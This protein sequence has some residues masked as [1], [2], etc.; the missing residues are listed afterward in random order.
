MGSDR[1]CRCP[2]E[3]GEGVLCTCGNNAP[4][5]WYL[6]LGFPNFENSIVCSWP[7]AG[8][9]MMCGCEYVGGEYALPLVG[10]NEKT[11]CGGVPLFRS[12]LWRYMDCSGDVCFII[13]G[14]PVWPG[15][16]I[17]LYTCPNHYKLII[18]FMLVYDDGCGVACASWRQAVYHSDLY[19]GN[20]CFELMD[21]DG[22]VPLSLIG[23]TSGGSDPCS[24]L[25]PDTIHIWPE[26]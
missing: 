12:C 25:W 4:E 3:E 21:E 11:G 15:L 19:S 2:E 23:S 14:V 17:E 8:P 5:T 16:R 20:D 18:R 22:R 13:Q 6:D 7:Y 10:I 9:Y 1:C 24:G 26:P